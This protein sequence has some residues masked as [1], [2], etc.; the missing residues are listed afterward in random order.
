MPSRSAA[1]R[2]LMQAAARDK[3][4]A[5]SAGIPQSVAQDFALADQL[6]KRQKAMGRIVKRRRAKGL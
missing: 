5:K 2:R 1:Q 4:I 6:Q 3:T